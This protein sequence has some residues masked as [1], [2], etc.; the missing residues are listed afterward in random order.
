M[1]VSNLQVDFIWLFIRS[2]TMSYMVCLLDVIK[3]RELKLVKR[4]DTNKE[5]LI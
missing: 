2:K 5:S 4:Y 1:T 3:T